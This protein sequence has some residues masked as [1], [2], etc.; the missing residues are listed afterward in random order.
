MNTTLQIDPATIGRVPL[1]ANLPPEE[2]AYLAATLQ[3]AELEPGTMLFREGETGDHFY[4]VLAGTIAIVKALGT[5]N[6]RLVGIWGRGEFVGEMSLL[7]ADG[8][9]TASVCVH[10]RAQVL[11]LSRADFDAL[12]R[13]QPPLVYTMLQILSTR[14]RESHEAALQDLHTKNQQLAQAYL[15]LQATQSQLI[16]QET[17]ARELQMARTIQ[18]RM[19]PQQLPRLGGCE[20]G[21]R[22]LPARSVG[23]DF[24]DVI[25]LDADR[26]VL[27]VGDVSGKA[28][29]AALYM[30]L[31]S[32]MLH[33]EATRAVT[34]EAALREL[35]DQLLCRDMESMFLTA[36]YGVLDR[37][38]CSF[39][40]VRAGHP[41][42]LVL[43]AQGNDY[44]PPI[45]PGQPLGLFP[46]FKLDVQTV[47][48]PP[49]GVL[50]LYSDGI[51][52]ASDA[53]CELFGAERLAMVVRANM[54]LPAHALRDTLVGAVQAFHSAST[55]DDD[56][57]VLAVR[58][59]WAAR[60]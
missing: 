2:L 16:E 29:P 21:A 8:L 51:T 24:Y 35:N 45:A 10:E 1:F 31:A 46:G 23:G 57:T 26:M 33:A 15:E 19:L 53:Q 6:E 50:L 34:P 58:A 36:I 60:R 49:G 12:L 32:S 55:Q 18:A 27:V 17:L 44:T 20:L 43:D 30:A 22:M 41:P 38:D 3:P 13:R 56:I 48:L 4:V 54:H 5:A 40:Y 28:M 25:P 47:T 7:S 11:R 42:P 52:E 39:S 37:R 14:L 59:T 9:R